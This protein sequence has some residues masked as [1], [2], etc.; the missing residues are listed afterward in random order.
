VE[1]TTAGGKTRTAPLSD[2]QFPACA[3]RAR[4]GRNDSSTAKERCPGAQ[5]SPSRKAIWCAA[6]ETQRGS[7]GAL[8]PDRCQ[9][10][11]SLFREPSPQP[12]GWTANGPAERPT[13]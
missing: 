6:R 11:V 2:P 3:I 10:S 4:R 8:G 5:R 12:A 7:A 9:A 13:G 1:K